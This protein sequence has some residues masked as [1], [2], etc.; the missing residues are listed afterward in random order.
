MDDIKK[1]IEDYLTPK[2]GNNA[3]DRMAQEYSDQAVSPWAILASGIGDAFAGRNP[4]SQWA[5]ELNKDTYNKTY[6]QYEKDYENAMRIAQLD[7][8]A[9][10]R[11]ATLQ[12]TMGNNQVKNALDAKTLERQTQKDLTEAQHQQTMEALRRMEVQNQIIQKKQKDQELSTAEAKNLGAAK[13]GGMAAK[14]YSDAVAKGQSTGENDRTNPWEFIDNTRWMPNVF[15]SDSALAAQTAEDAWGEQYLR[16]ES[17]AAI[18]ESERGPY[19]SLYFPRRGDTP[20]VVANKQALREQ[21]EKNYLL[22]AGKVGSDLAKQLPDKKI[23]AKTPVKK[24]HNEK[25]NKTK[26]VYSDGSEEVVDGLQ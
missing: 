21:K 4:N 1:Q 19:L 20:E 13:L 25:A 15:K 14:Q 22:G 16:S 18:P 3:K 7:Q 12:A 17:G 8:A 5:N 26:I 10:D 2:Y 24:F 11:E 23:E 6:G 9:K